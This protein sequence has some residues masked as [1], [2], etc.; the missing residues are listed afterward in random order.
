MVRALKA[1]LGTSFEMQNTS[2]MHLVEHA[3]GVQ[4]RHLLYRA[5][6]R[7]DPSVIRDD[8]LNFGKRPVRRQIVVSGCD[9]GSVRQVRP[10]VGGAVHKPG[11][12]VFGAADRALKPKHLD[13]LERCFAC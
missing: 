5:V 12:F 3:L 2:T 13:V 10:I 9:I 8:F 4:P 7:H 1:G 11:F 6:C